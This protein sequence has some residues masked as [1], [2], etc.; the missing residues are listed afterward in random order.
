ML[1][2]DFIIEKSKKERIDRITIE[3]EYWQLIFL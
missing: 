2:Y 1:D 3:R